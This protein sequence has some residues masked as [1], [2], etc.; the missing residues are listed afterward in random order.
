MQHMCI[1]SST[2]LQF[3]LKAFYRRHEEVIAE[4]I[5]Q[6]DLCV[7]ELAAIEER[8]DLDTD[9]KHFKRRMQMEGQLED[10]VKEHVNSDYWNN[11][12]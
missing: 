9:R 4:I 2:P 11:T 7:T 5:L 8:L 10:N 1:L 6:R 12:E 3:G